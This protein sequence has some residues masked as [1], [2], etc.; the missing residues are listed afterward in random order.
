MHCIS[1]HLD[2]HDEQI[3]SEKRESKKLNPIPSTVQ[4]KYIGL[5]VAIS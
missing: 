5:E 2:S 1:L 4:Q 3:V